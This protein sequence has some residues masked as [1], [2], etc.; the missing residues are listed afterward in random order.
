MNLKTFVPNCDEKET[1]CICNLF[2]SIISTTDHW[3]RYPFNKKITHL[4]LQQQKY[5][6]CNA[7]LPQWCNHLTRTSL[8][9]WFPNAW[10]KW[11]C[12]TQLAAM[13]L[14][15]CNSS[16]SKTV[17]NADS[18]PIGGNLKVYL[19]IFGGVNLV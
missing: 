13:I 9:T 5:I 4:C 16:L 2:L 8:I 18:G 3:R 12:T 19:S 11:D 15:T 17:V 6:E 7:W 1:G 10:A 14:P